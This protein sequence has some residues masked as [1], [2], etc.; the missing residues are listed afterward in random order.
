MSATNVLLVL[1]E[2]AQPQL[3]ELRTER[4]KIIEALRVCQGKI[5]ELE[6]HIL[7]KDLNDDSGLQ[8]TLRT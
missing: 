3:D 1:K 6:L 5:T 4:D 2:Q 8:D 7:V